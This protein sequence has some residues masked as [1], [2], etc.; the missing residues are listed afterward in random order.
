LFVAVLCCCLCCF[1][2][3][4]VITGRDFV[5]RGA[6]LKHL[7][8]EVWESHFSQISRAFLD[9]YKGDTCVPTGNGVSIEHKW[10]VP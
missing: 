4:R 6:V 9:F 1:L 8:F 3:L 7:H 2:V 5:N 10:A